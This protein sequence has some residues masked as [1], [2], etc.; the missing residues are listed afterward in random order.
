MAQGIIVSRGMD[1]VFCND[2]KVYEGELNYY[3]AKVIQHAT[4][5]AAPYHNLRHMLHVTWLCY[6]AC[7]YYKAQ[8]DFEMRSRRALMLAG[9]IHDFDHIGKAGDD[10]V[11]ILRAQQ[12]LRLHL[13]PDDEDLFDEVNGYI[14]IT[15][16]PYLQPTKDLPLM[17]QILR[18][19]DM[20]QTLSE[21]WLHQV[22]QGLAMEA[23]CSF[24]E[25]LSRQPGFLSKLTFH[26]EWGKATFPQKVID[27]RIFEVQRLLAGLHKCA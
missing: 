6:Q 1:V 8:E 15:E 22:V 23:G 12:G 3:F 4:N 2:H 9:L 27:A 16:Y 5:L 20:G 7:L 10:H 19:A 25:M 13:H 17:A 24:E 18:D 11:N 21:A 26:T 14:G